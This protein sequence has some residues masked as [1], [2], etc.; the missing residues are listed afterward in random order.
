MDNRMTQDALIEDALNSKPLAP[1]PRSIT[2]D[3]MARIQQDAKPTLLTWKDI[4]FS[5]VMASFISA[6]WLASQHL[7]PILL[8]KI[9]IQGILLYQDFLVNARWLV[10]ATLF[11]L[12]AFLAAVTIP[13][14]IQMTYKTSPRV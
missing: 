2:L 7:P 3:V 14:L 11:G 9:R 8:A 1:M 12:A 6:V 4:V 5:A 10:P 13:T